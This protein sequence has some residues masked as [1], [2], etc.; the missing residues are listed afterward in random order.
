MATGNRLADLSA[1]EAAL[2]SVTPVLAVR[3]PD[4]G[5]MTLPDNPEYSETD[6]KWINS[7]PMT[8]F[9]NG[10]WEDS[11]S[12]PILPEQL[13]IELLRKIHNA[14]HLGA[15]KM[16]D[17]VRTAKIV[18][19]DYRVKIE[20]IASDCKACLLTNPTKTSGATKG[21]RE[22][23]TRPGAYWE[24]D[25]TEVKLGQYGYR[26]LLVFIDTFSGWVEAYPTKKE[27]AKVVTKKLSEEILPRFGFPAQVGSDNGPVFVS[28][29]SQ[30][31]AAVLGTNWKLHCAYRPQSSGQVER[32][33]R[34]LKETLTKLTL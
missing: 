17:L 21:A 30:G 16:Q 4:P 31:L 27:T 5:T 28:K 11:K 18:I 33:N 3:I 12:A 26:Y 1:K 10:W 13:G 34:T 25:F 9:K 2:A 14:T 7:L 24:V 15:K 8:Q 20:K 6:I 23:G 22:R 32:M 19:K 29:V